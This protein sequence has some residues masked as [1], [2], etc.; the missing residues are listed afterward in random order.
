MIIDRGVI[1]PE[2]YAFPDPEPQDPTI[3]ST[4]D[5]LRKLKKDMEKKNAEQEKVNAENAK[6]KI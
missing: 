2:S 3:D 6:L 5:F 1:G 4:I